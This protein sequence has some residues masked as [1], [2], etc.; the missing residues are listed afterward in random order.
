MSIR[1][2]IKVINKE[3]G[4]V[5]F[6]DQYIGNNELTNMGNVVYADQTKEEMEEA[7]K[8]H[9][10]V[11]LIYNEEWDIHE[12]VWRPDVKE[13]VDDLIEYQNECTNRMLALHDGDVETTFKRVYSDA[14]IARAIGDSMPYIC[15]IEFVMRDLKK[16][17]NLGWVEDKGRRVY[18]WESWS[19]R[20]KYYVEITAG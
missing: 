17:I 12:L 7:A 9:E 19:G 18:L 4:E 16:Y 11:H 1:Q 20:T 5:V 14:F 3:T 15:V 6:E 10:N 13:F 2:Y 8:K